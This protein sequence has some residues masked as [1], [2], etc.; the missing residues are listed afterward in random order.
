[1]SKIKKILFVVNNLNCGGAE[2]ALLSL[3][4]TLDYSQVEVD[5][6]VVK[7]E[8]VFFKSLPKEIKVLPEPKNIRFF[9]MS[10]IKSL[11]LSLVSLKF[12]VF[13]A[14]IMLSLLA[15]KHKNG[16]VLEQYFWNYFSKIFTKLDDKY[17]V[18]IGFQEK[19]PIYFCIDKVN[20]TKKIG[21]IHTDLEVLEL[22]FN[23]DIEYFNKLD[24]IVTV[25]DGLTE[26]LKLKLPQFKSKIATIENII[27]AKIISNLAKEIVA[28]NPDKNAFTIIFVGRIAKEKGLFLGL[29]AIEILINKNYKI[30]WFLIGEGNM[31][32]ELRRQAIEKRIQNSIHFLGLKENPYPYLNKSDL[33]LL[34]SLFE[35]KS[36][37]LEEAKLLHKPIVITNFSSAKDQIEDGLN[38][39]IAEMN[40]ESIANAIEKLIVNKDLRDQF[41]TELA[42]TT[43]G[44]ESEITKFYQI[45]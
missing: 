29:D 2:K 40:S 30:N 26:R 10:T 39:F 28:F 20:A 36:I 38:G 13:Y 9:Y 16:V 14:R 18:A 42:A 43:K 4:Q 31:K 12:K 21:W 6:F 24:N 5:L 22:D 1:M 3:L 15:K 11:F 25:S 23:K 41:S 17:D 33:F 19:T 27:S 35:G 37:S 32:E 7:H 8:G 34:P 44:N 45:L